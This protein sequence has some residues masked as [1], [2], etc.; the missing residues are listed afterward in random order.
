MMPGPAAEKAMEAEEA[1]TSQTVVAEGGNQSTLPLAPADELPMPLPRPP[2]LRILGQ[3][4]K[5]YIVAEGEDGLVLIDQHAAAERIR[6]EMLQESYRSRKIRQDLLAPLSIELSAS[7]RVV[8]ATWQETLQ[9][10]GF[11]ISPFGGTLTPCELSLP[12]AATWRALTACT[13]S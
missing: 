1:R 11:D 3:I 5:L 9:D 10:I 12:R 7:E 4:K 6:F 8:L 2:K 13:I